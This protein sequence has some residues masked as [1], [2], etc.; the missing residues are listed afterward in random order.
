METDY[1]ACDP[2]A[3]KRR[4]EVN[5]L[6]LFRLFITKRFHGEIAE[7]MDDGIQ[8]SLRRLLLFTNTIPQVSKRDHESRQDGHQAFLTDLAEYWRS[9]PDNEEMMKYKDIWEHVAQRPLPWELLPEWAPSVQYDGHRRKV[10]EELGLKSLLMM[11]KKVR[12]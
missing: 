9:L 8:A 6:L 4:Y 1:P 3:V 2:T 11:T 7:E 10:G 5:M 12:T